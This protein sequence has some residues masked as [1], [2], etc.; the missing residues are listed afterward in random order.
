MGGR[1]SRTS[2]GCLTTSNS[3]TAGSGR[4]VLLGVTERL[5][6]VDAPCHVADLARY[7]ARGYAMK[8]NRIRFV[9]RRPVA[10]DGR[11]R[12]LAQ[13]RADM[14]LASPDR[15]VAPAREVLR[16]GGHSGR[17]NSAVPPAWV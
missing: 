5:E 4:P 15:S 3:Y 11:S 14:G 6:F 2:H 17:A 9:A 1:T 13:S 7:R 16:S 8:G 12:G 10:G